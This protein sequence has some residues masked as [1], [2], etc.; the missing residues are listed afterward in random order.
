MG[1]GAIGSKAFNYVKRGVKMAPDFVL[2]TGNEV[3][4]KLLQIHFTVSKILPENVKAESTLKTSG[5]N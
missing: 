1:I 4:Q 5:H 2:G 3:F